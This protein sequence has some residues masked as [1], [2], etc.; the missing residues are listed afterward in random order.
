MKHEIRAM[1]AN[2]NPGSIVNTSSIGGLVGGSTNNDYASSKWGLAGLVRCA[3]L[4]YAR[5]GIRVNAIAP[6]S[7]HSEMFD[8]WINSEEARQVAAG[9]SP[10]RHIADPDDMARAALLLLSDEARFTTGVVFP[11]DGG[12][13]AG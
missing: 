3:A 11:C 13:F 1:L 9:W 5:N 7:T 4:G 8:Y 6:G 2:G 10:M 12:M